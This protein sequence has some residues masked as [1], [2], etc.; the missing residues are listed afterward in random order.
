MTQNICCGYFAFDR[1]LI[2]EMVM[3][4][5]QYRE[6]QHVEVESYGLAQCFS[7]LFHSIAPFSLSTRRFRPP[8]LIKRTQGSTFK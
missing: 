3:G 5:A 2:V 6:T 8:S 7:Y 4:L 1:T